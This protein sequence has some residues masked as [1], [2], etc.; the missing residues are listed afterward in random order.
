MSNVH[1]SKHPLVQ[2]W[3]AQLRD[4]ATPPVAFRR[5]VHDLSQILFIEASADLALEEITVETPMTSCPAKRLNERIGLIPIL[6]AGLG[7]AQAVLDFIP[8]AQVWHLGL[9]RDHETCQPVTYYNKLNAGAGLDRCFVVDPMLATGG[10]AVAAIEILKE[11]GVT[12]ICLLS[13]IS[14]PIGVELL[15]AAHPDVPIYLAALD[16]HLDENKYII[17]G[18]GDAGDRQF[19]TAL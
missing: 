14:S 5:L 11:R 10:S 2:H 1:I 18:L 17:P 3:L 13:L 12:R 4:K 19:A 15:R 8:E 6:R 9:Y 7:M 16:S